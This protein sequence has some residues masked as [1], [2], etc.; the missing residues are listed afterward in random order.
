M[1]RVLELVMFFGLATVLG[2]IAIRLYES[3][4]GK[5]LWDYFVV[6]EPAPKGSQPAWFKDVMKEV[7]APGFDFKPVEFQNNFTLD[8]P[9]WPKGAFDWKDESATPKRERRKSSPNRTDSFKSRRERS[10][11]ARQPS[12]PTSGPW[13]GEN[14]FAK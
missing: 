7:T 2:T 13:M 14:P 8:G 3:P 12:R 1:K 11:S 6:R 10:P 4:D 5:M 9:I